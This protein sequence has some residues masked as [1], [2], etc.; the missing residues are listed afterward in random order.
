M[1]EQFLNRFLNYVQVNTRSDS[2]SETVPSTP[3]QLSM[4]RILKE[5]LETMGLEA[6]SLDDNG[7]LMA[8]LPANTDKSVPAIGF[9]AHMDTAPD[10][11]GEGV[12]PQVID[13]YDGSEICP[14]CG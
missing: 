4:A 3:G 1:Q 13:S 11:S 9:V 12:S 5:E 7:Y 6:I 8:R 2:A 14:E 10:A